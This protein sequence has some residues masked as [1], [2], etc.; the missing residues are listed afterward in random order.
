MCKAPNFRHHAIVHL[1]RGLI[2]PPSNCLAS[3]IFETSRKSNL[4]AI[5]LQHWISELMAFFP[6]WHLHLSQKIFL[7]LL[8]HWCECLKTACPKAHLETL[9]TNPCN[10]HAD[11]PLSSG[12]HVPSLFEE[13]APWDKVDALLLE[14]REVFHSWCYKCKFLLQKVLMHMQNMY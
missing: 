2:H 5:S 8:V 13:Q 14:K 3:L 9:S 1:P 10:Q 11:C 7:Q 12:P 6:L 4:L